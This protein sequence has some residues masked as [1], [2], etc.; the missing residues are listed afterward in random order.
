MEDSLGVIH[1]SEFIFNALISSILANILANFALV[2]RLVRHIY[3][4]VS[5]DELDLPLKSIRVR[6]WI[7]PVSVED[8]HLI[9]MNAFRDSG[10]FGLIVS[11]GAPFSSISLNWSEK[12]LKVFRFHYRN[13]WQFFRFM[14]RGK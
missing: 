10:C 12:S 9:I 4:I 2:F 5:V 7:A 6:E 8:G 14:L 13:D 1:D 3:A 11:R